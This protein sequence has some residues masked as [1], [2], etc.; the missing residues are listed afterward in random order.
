MKALL[1]LEDSLIILYQKK[2]GEG[3]SGRGDNYIEYISERDNNRNLSPK[4]YL[5][6]IRSYL[7]YLINH[8]KASREWKIQFVILNR[9]ISSKNYEETRDMYS[10][11]NNI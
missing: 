4:E 9:C 1:I 8:H 5:K 2:T 10:A 7:I 11:S 3:F 6:I